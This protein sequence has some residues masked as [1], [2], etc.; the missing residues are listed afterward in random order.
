MPKLSQFYITC[1]N[2]VQFDHDLWNLDY[3]EKSVLKLMADP[4]CTR[5]AIKYDC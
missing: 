4:V 1:R 2:V 3:F 5:S